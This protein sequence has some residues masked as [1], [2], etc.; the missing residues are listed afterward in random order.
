MKRYMHTAWIVTSVICSTSVFAGSVLRLDE[1]PIGELDPAKALDTADSILMFNVYDT[2]LIPE[3]GSTQFKPLLATK[4]ETSDSIHYTFDLRDDVKFHSGNMLTAED[5]VYSFNR[6]M[7]LGQGFSYLYGNVESVEVVDSD[8]VSFTLKQ[9]YSPFLSSLVHLPI[10]DKKLVMQHLADGEGANKD[11]GQA[12]LNLNDA[13]SGAYTVSSHNPQSETVMEKN[14]DYFLDIPAKSP[15]T[16]RMRYGLEPSTVR[17][18]MKQG[19]HDISS[20]WLP[21]EVL[22]S[23]ANEGMQLLS[24]H[25]S[26]E[27]YI[28]FNT[29]KAPFDDVECRLAVANAFD[30]ASGIKMVQVTSDVSQGSE[31]TGALPKGMLGALPAT[32]AF[33][34]KQDLAAAKEHL[35]KCQYSPDEMN[36]ELSWIAEVPLE[37]RFALLMQ[38]NLA[39]IGL[40][41]TIRK[42]PW[43]MFTELVTKPETTPSISQ[44]FISS[45]TGDPDSILYAA[46]HSSKSG[47]W[48]SPEYLK[49]EK[50]D[51]L[52]EKGRQVPQAEREAVYQELNKRLR[53]L[54]P[55]IFAQDQIS[56]FAATPRV[57]APALSDP[58]LGYT[59]D[60]FGFN[61]RFIEVSD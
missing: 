30:Y 2:L 49:D 59:V 40:K 20:Q 53:E 42:V 54:A 24:Q 3:A 46:Y 17:T 41:A 48:L 39:Q 15:D 21:P 43:A 26:S 34:Y 45:V 52:L 7:A 31:A 37:K 38:A 29:A 23:L 8:T 28:K 10:V 32:D 51:A 14:P 19:K 47:T 6:M 4:W 22:K 11:W 55:A 9:P 33:T 18:L 50:V 44:V 27:F 12:Y 25:G 60:G 13:G 5:V 16:V 35:A 57:H 58:K 56:V 1:S 36:I 61:F